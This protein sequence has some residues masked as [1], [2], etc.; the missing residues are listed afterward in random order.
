MGGI[1]GEVGGHVRQL[2]GDLSRRQGS[3]LCRETLNAVAE[4]SCKGRELR[5]TSQDTVSCHQKT[6]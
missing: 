5:P 4:N 3:D 6:M 1:S 2:Y